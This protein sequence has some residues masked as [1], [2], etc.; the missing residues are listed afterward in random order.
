MRKFLAG[1]AL[2]ALPLVAAA[3]SAGLA[4]Q[5]ELAMQAYL[6]R[7][8]AS[9]ALVVHDD[10]L[11]RDW[12]LK[13]QKL[14]PA[15]V[16]Q[17]D[18]R[19]GIACAEFRK[20]DDGFFRRLFHPTKLDLDLYMRKDRAGWSVQQVLIHKVQGVARYQYDANHQRVPIAPE[21]ESAL[22]PSAPPAAAPAA[23]ATAPAAAPTTAPAAADPAAAAAAAA[24]PATPAVT[25]PAPDSAA[26]TPTPV[27][28]APVPAAAA[29]APITGPAPNAP[30]S[31]SN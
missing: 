27:P 10:V 20:A 7:T 2:A 4:T 3:Q 6:A 26:P 22:A 14:D 30:A 18:G 13:L 21:S 11:N 9:G 17:V 15:T 8:E 12:K 28:S 5:F 24:A 25:A 16:V 29:A 23:P 31:S 1:L 19:D